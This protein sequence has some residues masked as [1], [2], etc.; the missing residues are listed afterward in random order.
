MKK[1]EQIRPIEAKVTEYGP[2]WT[3]GWYRLEI[4]I[5]YPQKVRAEFR[6]STDNGSGEPATELNLESQRVSVRWP[7]G[8]EQTFSIRDEIDRGFG[9]KRPGRR[10]KV[11][12]ERPR[13]VVRA[14][15]TWGAGLELRLTGGVTA[16]A[17]TIPA[18]LITHP[19]RNAHWM[20]LGEEG[21]NVEGPFFSGHG[22]RRQVVQ[23]A[24]PLRSLINDFLGLPKYGVEGGRVRSRKKARA[25]RANGRKGGRPR[26]AIAES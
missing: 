10:P 24:I 12:Q 5:M 6:F 11:A 3:E 26:K 7:D 19:Q 8:E 18:K 13:P 14:S 9:F 23:K 17:V 15:T 21:E 20:R 2:G 25:A 16:T 22:S 1:K 4:V